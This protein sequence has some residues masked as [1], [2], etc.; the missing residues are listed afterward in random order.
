[1]VLMVGCEFL[2]ST[3]LGGGS[4]RQLKNSSMFLVGLYLDSDAV[5]VDSWWNVL[6]TLLSATLCLS[7]ELK[8]LL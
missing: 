6:R 3:G 1:M 8:G 4:L 7:L 2:S 5:L